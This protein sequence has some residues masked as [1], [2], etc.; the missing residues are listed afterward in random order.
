MLVAE[1]HYINFALSAWP[2]PL[3]VLP[4]VARFM[5]GPGTQDSCFSAVLFPD[6][7]KQQCQPSCFFK[8][9]KKTCWEESC[10]GLA[11]ESF[12]INLGFVQSNIS[13]RAVKSPSPQ[14]QKR[15]AVGD[16][17]GEVFPG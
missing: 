4:L 11:Q 7:L 6:Q 13:Q 2:L 16:G 10:S 3:G 15:E 1:L 12:M 17:A 8:G 5:P 9:E 14:H